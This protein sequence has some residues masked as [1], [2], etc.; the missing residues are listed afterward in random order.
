VRESLL[1]QRAAGSVRSA[2][3]C[4]GHRKGKSPGET[5]EGGE[6]EADDE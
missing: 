2:Q 3:E 6:A 4:P 1:L 5:P